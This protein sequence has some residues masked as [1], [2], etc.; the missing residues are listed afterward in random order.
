MDKWINAEIEVPV[1]ED[2]VLV[3][4]SGNYDN[5]TFVD[6]VE[7]AEYD[8]KEDEWVL[9]WLPE[10]T[11]LKVKYWCPVPELPKECEAK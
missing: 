7:L 6:A 8:P 5:M 3:I 4:V 11:G 9:Q 2:L 10:V 1:V